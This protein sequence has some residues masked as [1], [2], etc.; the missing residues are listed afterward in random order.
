M[1]DIE[2]EFGKALDEE[3]GLEFAKQYKLTEEQIQKARETQ[4]QSNKL[5][6]TCIIDT[7]IV[8]EI[9]KTVEK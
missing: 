2:Y 7:H 3:I 8:N 9:L 6:S 4:E 1:I 5:F